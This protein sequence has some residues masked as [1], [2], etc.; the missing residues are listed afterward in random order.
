MGLVTVPPRR[1]DRHGRS[2]RVHG[3]GQIRADALKAER[4]DR[5]GDRVL[6]GLEEPVEAPWRE[7]V[8]RCD[9]RVRQAG[10]GE[11][12]SDVG[13]DLRSSRVLGHRLRHFR[14]A[15]QAGHELHAG[16]AELLA[17]RGAGAPLRLPDGRG[18]EVVQHRARAVLGTEGAGHGRGDHSR[19]DTEGVSRQGHHRADPVALEA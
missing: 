12:G 14:T 4:T 15:Q 9:A 6:L 13:E 11:I 10:V 19:R 18:D 5:L 3:V 17:A 2:V 8:R 7:S 1:G 16:L